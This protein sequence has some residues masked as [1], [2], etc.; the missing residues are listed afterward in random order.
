MN[1]GVVRCGR[2]LLAVVVLGLGF[3][4]CGGGDPQP[5][6]PDP[7][8]GTWQTYVLSS[9]DEIDVPEP[10][11]GDK[12]QAEQR[13]LQQLAR[14]RTPE[15]EEKVERWNQVPAL[16]PWIDLNIEMVAHG[17]KD[18]P[19][20]SRGYAY[21]SIAIYDAMLAAWHWKYEY[22]REPPEGVTALVDTAPGPSYPSEHAAM[23]GAASRVLAHLFPE[24]PVG[25][26]DE[27][28]E[29]AATSRLQAG[30]NFRSDVDA[31]L[32]LGRAVP[33]KVIARAKA[34][35]ADKV[36][37]GERPPG[38]GR[39]P[40]F[41]EPPPG[42]ITPPTQ[43]LAGTWKTWILESPSQFRAPPPFAYGTPEFLAEVKEVMEIRA[44]LT[45]DQEAI[46][47]F[48]AGGQG[49]ALP[50]GIWNQV[51]LVYAAGS[52]LD[53]PR[54]ARLFAGLNAA[55][56]DAALAVWDTKFTYWTARPLN[57]IRDLGLDP[58]WRPVLGTPS[59][60]SY[61]SGHS[62]YSAAAAA[63][64]SHFFPT[65]R[66]TF[67]AKAQEAALSRLYGGI[68]Y[69]SDNDQGAVMGKKVG[70]L[71]VERLKRDGAEV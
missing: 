56:N 11:S 45:P 68:H 59:F 66:A 53:G 49:S 39:G 22:D 23:A 38:I 7:E 65:E 4:A 43:P 13:E 64:L 30:A 20:A 18:P 62:G 5:A 26:F 52:K 60:P 36:W 19:L 24:Q 61:V 58:N 40:Q 16:K 47:Q 42:T 44:K 41:W 33:E 27:L 37:D 2:I 6:G 34:D 71:T 32:A 67:D 15:I 3:A 17:V 9:A 54:A 21:T 35:G 25:I 51:A 10:P 46:A 69:R 8:A 50:P 48:W 14:S 29:E 63:V 28:A 1:G 55:Q 12:E 57:A 70:D 31:G